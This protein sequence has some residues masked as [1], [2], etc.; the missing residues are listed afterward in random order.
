MIGM[1]RCTQPQD[2]RRLDLR[3]EILTHAVN[4]ALDDVDGTGPEMG[5]PPF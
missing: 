1:R 2:G 3:I 5:Q 4:F